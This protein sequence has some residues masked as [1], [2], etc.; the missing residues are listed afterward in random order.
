MKPLV[1]LPLCTRE[2]PELCD[3]RLGVGGNYLVPNQAVSVLREMYPESDPM[4]MKEPKGPK[5][6]SIA[7]HVA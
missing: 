7:F 3:P 1:E 4:I 5:R 6:V 2:V